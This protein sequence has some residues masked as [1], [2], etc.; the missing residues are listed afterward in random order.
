MARD[1]RQVRPQRR[2]RPGEGQHC[3]GLPQS[4]GLPRGQGLLYVQEVFALTLT[5]IGP[6]FLGSISVGTS[7]FDNNNTCPVVVLPWANKAVASP[8]GSQVLHAT[9]GAVGCEVLVDMNDD[10][11]RFGIT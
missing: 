1:V 11:T 5:P 6:N 2:V 8:H 7:R 3:G 9:C 10:T 4:M